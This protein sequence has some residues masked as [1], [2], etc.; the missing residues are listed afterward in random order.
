VLELTLRTSVVLSVAWLAARLLRRASAATRHRVWHG[1][2]VA[3]LLCPIAAPLAPRLPIPTPAWTVPVTTAVS[4]PPSSRQTGETVDLSPR[5]SAPASQGAPPIAEAE[6]W[7]RALAPVA[8][9]GW[10]AG[11]L[12]VALWFLAGWIASAAAARRATRAPASWLRQVDELRDVMDLSRPVAVK[13]QARHASPLVVGF[14]QPTILLPAI[15]RAW[16]ADRRRAVLLHEL[17]HVQRG[18]CRVQALAQAVCA[19]YWFNPLCWIAAAALRTE[20]ER[21]CDE[22]VLRHGT[23]PSAYAAHLLEI[24]RDLSPRLRPTAALAMA[25]PAELEGRL[26]AVLAPD[27]PRIAS[28]ASSWLILAFTMSTTALALAVSP[29]GASAPVSALPVSR[30]HSPTAFDGE[31]LQSRAEG[32]RARTV[33]ASTLESAADPGARSRAALDLGASGTVDAIPSLAR[34]LSDDS[35]DV[36]EKAALALGLQSSPAV[37]PHLVMALADPSA[38]VREKAAL[39]LALRRDPRS[40]DALVAAAADPDAQVREKVAMA[41]GTSGDARAIAAIDALSSDPDAQVREKAV[42]ARSLLTTLT[43]NDEAAEQARAGIRTLV[44]RLLALIP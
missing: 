9:A 1:A 10:I 6:R 27:R 15:A 29:G 14:W 21:A 12:T 32:R 13:V 28:R 43:A 24:A 23:R 20:R 16:T 30:P 22:V 31:S 7:L 41:L 34:A 39:G 26:L 35:A 40:V 33:A 19:L 25:R 44:S 37:V 42:V 4:L 2:L 36:R 17:A 8:P 11:S 18:D 38:Q 5:A 3:V